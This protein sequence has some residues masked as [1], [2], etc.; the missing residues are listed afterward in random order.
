MIP[1]TAEE[2]VILVKA[3]DI[4]AVKALRPETGGALALGVHD[5]IKLI[6]R[7]SYVDAEMKT[8]S[9]P[10]DGLSGM[11]VS[12]QPPGEPP[13]SPGESGMPQPKIWGK[14][15]VPKH[16]VQPEAVPAQEKSRKVLDLD[17]DP[18]EPES[19]QERARSRTEEAERQ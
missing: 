14:P 11:A 5:G 10:P 4:L 13:E 6:L 19:G 7:V 2:L 18:S 16:P 12:M 15:F 8:D 17:D 9:P 3:R 1:M